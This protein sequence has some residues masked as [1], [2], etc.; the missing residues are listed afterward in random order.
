LIW[1]RKRA[2]DEIDRKGGKLEWSCSIDRYIIAFTMLTNGQ[3]S[4]N[5]LVISLIFV[6]LL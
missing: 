5:Y 1:P 6:S 4:P 3:K 2:S